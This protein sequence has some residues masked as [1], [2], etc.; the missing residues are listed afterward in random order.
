M[1]RHK[2]KSKAQL[3]EYTKQCCL[4]FCVEKHKQHKRVISKGTVCIVPGPSDTISVYVNH[5][6]VHYG[7]KDI[8]RKIHIDSI[9]NTVVAMEGFIY[10]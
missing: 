2:H 5:I 10:D 9:L 4:D 7:I 8:H 1:I 3:S 6:L